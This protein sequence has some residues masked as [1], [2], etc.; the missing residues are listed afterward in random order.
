MDRMTRAEMLNRL[1]KIEYTEIWPHD[2]WKDIGYT[3]L[4]IWVNGNGYG[5]FCHDEQ[6]ICYKLDR[7]PDQKWEIIQKKIAENKLT[8]D[9]VQGTSLTN[10]YIIKEYDP[11]VPCDLNEM[12]NELITLPKSLGEFFYCADT[13]GDYRFYNTENE[14][15]ESIKRDDCDTK[16]DELNDDELAEWIM[17]LESIDLGITFFDGWC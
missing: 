1:S 17:R 7:I 8:I 4:Q 5:Y 2:D 12:L 10:L 3:E 14:I 11:D 13:F 16:W 9:D 15:Y 6:S